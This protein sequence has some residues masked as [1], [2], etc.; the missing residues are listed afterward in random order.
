MVVKVDTLDKEYEPL[1]AQ[2]KEQGYLTLDD[3]AD[4]FPEAEENLDELEDVFVALNDQDIQVLYEDEDV[5]FEK[6]SEKLKD[7]DEEKEFRARTKPEEP[8]KL[9]EI[10]IDNSISLYLKEMARVP[11]LTAEQEVLLARQYE[12]GH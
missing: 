9:S 7:D 5:D 3:L 8:A 10:A 6:L 1:M 2:A 11:L 12:E 4:Y